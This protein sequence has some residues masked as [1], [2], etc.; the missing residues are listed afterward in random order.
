MDPAI[1]HPTLLSNLLQLGESGKTAAEY[2]QNH[3]TRIGFRRARSSVGAFWTP[4]GNIY[5]NSRRYTFDNSLTD[6][7]VLCLVLHETR[8]LQQGFFTALSVYGELEAWQLHFNAWQSMVDKPVHPAI[9]E[10]LSLPLGWERASLLR[11][12]TL[13]QD[14]AG[15][16]YRIDLLPLYPFGKEIRHRLGL[17]TFADKGLSHSK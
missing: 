14:F 10:L 13:M 9:S 2:L 1:W 8:H 7:Y 3:K 5:L 11:A 16:K 4:F 6:P 12:R 15:K 17:R